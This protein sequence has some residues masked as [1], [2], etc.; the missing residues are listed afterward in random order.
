MTDRA[1]KLALVGDLGGTHARLA[2]ADLAAPTPT[3]AGIREYPSAQFAAPDAL[4]RTY[5]AE[6]GRKPAVAAIA[7]AG[8]VVQ[9][10]VH[11]T[12]LG[13][14]LCEADLIALGFAQARLVNDFESLAWATELLRKQD[15][16]S[17]GPGCAGDPQASIGVIGP[18]TGFGASALVRGRGLSVAMATEGG[19]ASFAPGDETEQEILRLLSRRFPHVSIERVLSGPG[20]QNLHDALNA[21]E[22]VKEA[23][24]HPDEITRRALAGDSACARTLSRFCAILGAVAGDFALYYGARGGLF[25]AGGIAPAIF[26][27][28]EKSDFRRRFEAKGRFESYLRAVPTCVI[29]HP[30]A[31]FLGAAA[32]AR[33][34]ASGI[35]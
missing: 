3:M 9:G 32:L 12:N 15:L 27:V 4:L 11:F 1:A 25:I 18:G 34:L 16:R 19:H 35:R 8:P 2:L 20:L 10:E 24:P 31:A 22:G 23:T 5:L 30:H 33:R 17:L 28:L 14:R 6:S 7:V 26:P 21:I 29:V 13:W